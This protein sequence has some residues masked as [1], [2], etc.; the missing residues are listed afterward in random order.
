MDA[1]R[2]AKAACGR[3]AGGWLRLALVCYN[4]AGTGKVGRGSRGGQVMVATETVK[5]VVLVLF[6]LCILWIIVIVV[7]NDMQT[8]VRAL[9][10]TAVLGLALFLLTQPKIARHEKLSFDIIKNE[11]FPVKARNYAF[12]KR[13]S[14]VAGSPTTTY[15]FDEPGPPLPLVM[16]SGGKY[17]AIKDIR[18]VNVVLEFLGLPPITK[19]VSELA[20]ITGQAI[21]SDKYRWDDYAK[22]VL[23]LERGICRDMTAIQTFTCIA[24]ITI[25]AR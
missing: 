22:G 4:S 18:P 17:M 10:V 20:S 25:K 5:T 15:T 7:K 6:G 11:L 19:G 3:K 16:M 14:L 13:E 24:Q 21:D 8:I 23:L 12:Q 9:L 1:G 2:K